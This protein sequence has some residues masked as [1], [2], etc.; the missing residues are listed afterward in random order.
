MW[1]GFSTRACN[2]ESA[3]VEKPRH[4]FKGGNMADPTKGPQEQTKS[5]TTQPG[6]VPQTPAT[7]YGS[8]GTSQTGS[9]QGGQT[10]SAT[11]QARDQSQPSKS[12]TSFESEI[13][14][15][16]ERGEEVVEQ[17]REKF[18]D[19]YGRAS[20]GMN[21]TWDS[22]MTYSRENPG[23]ATL[24]AFGAGIGVGLLIANSF[25]TRS[26]TRRLVPPVMNALSEIAEELFR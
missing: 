8:R 12:G 13:Q 7:G 15:I 19:A 22:A 23:T 5:T 24:I 25:A 14:S 16:K 21:E 10:G 17:A 9:E 6:A 20:R 1:R 11:R 4:I 18:S 3:R 2:R 26:R